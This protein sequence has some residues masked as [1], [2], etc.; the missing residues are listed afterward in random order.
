MAISVIP[1]DKEVFMFRVYWKMFCAGDE[2]ICFKNF[3]SPKKAREYAA[4]V[5][6]WV[7]IARPLKMA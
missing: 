6:G 1:H 4:K 2:S 7:E 3:D 5:K